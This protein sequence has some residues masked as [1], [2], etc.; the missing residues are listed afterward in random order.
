MLQ[1]KLAR[2][3]HYFAV[4]YVITIG[5]YWTAIIL[6]SGEGEIIKLIASLFLIPIFLGLDQ[7][8]QRLLKIASGEWPEVID[9]SGEESIESGEPK[10][11]SRMNIKHYIPFIN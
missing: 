3:W 6:I 5:C 2:N 11:Q 4:F 9:L 8:A 10:G 1:R 7:W